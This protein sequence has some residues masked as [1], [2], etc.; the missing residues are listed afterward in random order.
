MS[1]ELHPFNSILPTLGADVFVAPGAHVIGDV[2]LGEGSSVWFN[3]VLRGD[4]APLR[5]G[6]RTNIQD[7]SVLHVSSGFPTTLGDD[8]TVGH[9]AIIH[10]CTI[11]SE[12]LIGMGAIILDGAYIEEGCL[13]A[14]GALVPPGKRVPA[15]SVYMG[16][17][18]KVRRPTSPQDRQSFLASALHYAELGKLYLGHQPG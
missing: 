10:G 14:A 16:A 15:G 18:G 2:V 3:A 4:I 9:R 17:P 11:E 5:I 1:R 8:V 7:L 6:A 13:I 12:C